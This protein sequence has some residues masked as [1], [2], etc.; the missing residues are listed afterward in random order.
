MK[1]FIAW[2]ALILLL[3]IGLLL[4]W[5]MIDDDPGVDQPPTVNGADLIWAQALFRKHDPRQGAP[6]VLQSLSLTTGEVNRLLNY[7]VALKSIYGMEAEL[8]PGSA[9]IDTSLKLPHTPFGDYLNVSVELQADHGVATIAAVQLGDLALPGVLARW[10]GQLA[11]RMLSRD[12]AYAAITLSIRRVDFQEDRVTLDYA[13]QPQLLTQLQRKSAALLID[14]AE[15]TRMLAYAN[16][17]QKQIRPLPQGARLSLY[18]LVQPVFA[19][20]ATRSG[21]AAA[22]NRAAVTALAAYVGGVSLPHLL[23]NKGMNIRREPPVLPRLHGRADFSQHYLIAAALSVNGGSGFA[24]ALGLAK[25]EDDAVGGSGFSF[26]DLA[27]DRA[28][29]RL[30]ERLS[31]ADAVL[32]QQRLAHAD[33]DADLMPDFSDLPE[34]MPD[35]EF[36]RRFGGVGSARYDAMIHEIDKRLILH[37]LLGPATQ[38]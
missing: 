29:A 26:T 14:D 30:G 37:P 12:P 13:W 8:T 1:R 33:S 18:R 31:G 5:L 4:P 10:G 16:F 36:K 23:Q 9:I 25:E 28:A 27:A 19:Y 11:H 2:S 15:R 34:F 7:A 24:N 35:A 3:A 20:A 21:D 38:R 17:I 6:G 22:E 32:T